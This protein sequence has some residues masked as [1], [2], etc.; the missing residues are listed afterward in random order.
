MER[1][2]IACIAPLCFVD[3]M[4]KLS[5]KDLK[6]IAANDEYIASKDMDIEFK[7][8]FIEFLKDKPTFVKSKL[9]LFHILETPFPGLD[10][11]FFSTEKGKE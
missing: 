5:E 7:F 9:K 3:S 8:K 1:P 2:T 10:K 4:D 6:K 11:I